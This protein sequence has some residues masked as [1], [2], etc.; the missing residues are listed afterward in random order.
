LLSTTVMIAPLERLQLQNLGNSFLMNIAGIATSTLLYGTFV[1]LF[2][3][4][5]IA[6]LQR[7]SKSRATWTIFGATVA[8]FLLATL[9]WTAHVA[10]FATYIRK[11]LI[12][13]VNGPL[14]SAYPYD[15]DERIFSMNQVMN[16]T[17]QG[18]Q[19]INDVIVIWRAYVLCAGH[20]WAVFGPSL[21]LIGTCATSFAFLGITSSFWRL[22]AYYSG[23]RVT[24]DLLYATGAL[25]L[26]TNVLSVMLIAYRLW[27]CRKNWNVALGNRWSH[28]QKILLMIVE[29]GAVYGLCQL[30][31]ML[32]IRKGAKSRVPVPGP[33]KPIDYFSFI[34]WEAYIRTT[35]MYPT[36][37]LL[38]IYQKRSF[39]D[40]DGFVATSVRPT[41]V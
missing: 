22:E 1:L 13:G 2:S 41:H 28:A 19:I 16:W 27:A 18:L 40:I 35:A 34:V 9:H 15:S 25:S 4:S 29:S 21:L 3:L 20:H 5:T 37:V 17:L 24:H 14:D 8:S 23:D 36:I 31:A 38:L 32:A 6:V 12:E 10:F 26:A 30:A 11:A 7:R 33:R 39:A